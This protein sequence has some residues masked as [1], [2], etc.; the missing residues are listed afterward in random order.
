MPTCTPLG[1]DGQRLFQKF[2][3][4]LVITGLSLFLLTGCSNSGASASA[5]GGGAPSGKGGGGRRGGGGDVPVTVTKAAQKNVP[6]E[7]QVI[8][9]VEAYSTI[10]MKAQ[11]PGQLTHVYFQEGD[12]VKKD[13]PLFTIDPRPLEAAMNQA[14]A[15]LAKDQ[16]ALGQFQANLARDTAQA[17]YQEAQAARYAQLAQS[18]IISKDQ[19]E[20]VRAN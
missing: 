18:G 19:A 4:I 6:V 8:G 2:F 15:N 1:C 11:V 14:Q 17:R 7:I 9:N 16:A 13:D 5:A 10:S 12:Y 3:W 20:Q